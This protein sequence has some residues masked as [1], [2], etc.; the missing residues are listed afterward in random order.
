VV[1][2]RTRVITL[3]RLKLA[4]DGDKLALL[5]D[6]LSIPDVLPN[7]VE[8]NLERLFWSIF[9]LGLWLNILNLLVN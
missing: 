2:L 1:V 7:F 5:N 3:H 8:L 4:G 9:P 6:L